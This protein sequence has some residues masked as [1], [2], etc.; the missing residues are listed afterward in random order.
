MKVVIDTTIL[1]YE[2]IGQGEKNL[3][4]LHGWGRSLREWIPIA[5]SLTGYKVT[6]LDLPGFGSSEEAS[7]AIDTYEYSEIVLKFIK[8]L[9]IAPCRIVGHSFGGRI[10]TIL[11]A[12]YP[13]IVSKIILV[14]AGGIEIKSLGVQVK[15]I[16]YKLILKHF[17]NLIPRRIKNFFGSSNYRVL[18][19]NLRKSF[20]KIVNQ[21]LRSLFSIIKQPVVVIWGS[22][23]RV[24][25]VQY[26]KI[27]RKL[28]P[29][30][31]VRIIWG[32][33]H[34]P[35]VEKHKDFISIL[36]EVL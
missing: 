9:E 18:S 33:G 22:D 7:G 11:A 12:Q 21:D 32:A 25:S 10:A 5:H 35:H 28:I 27:Y 17:K 13:E 36:Q 30:A 1:H 2:Q 6:L 23:D 3:L 24:L 34:C 29:Q 20:V 26:V 15:I 4:V 8:K 14:D 19:G 31:L 16:L